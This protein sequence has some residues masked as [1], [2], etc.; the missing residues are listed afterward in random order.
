MNGKVVST[1]HLQIR[2]TVQDYIQAKLEELKQPVNLEKPKG[3]EQLVEA[4]YKALLSK[5][6]RKYSA[7][8]DL[9]KHIM[10]A[11]RINVEKNEPINI[12]FLHG[13]YKLWRLEETPEADWA[14]L[15]SLMYYSNW[16][17]PIC[18]IYEPG[19][20]F[21]FF[22]D[23]LII[24]KLDNIDLADVTAYMDSYQSLI[25]F[26]KQ[27]QPSNLKMTITTVGG[28]F[29]SP[30]A[31]DESV[32]SNLEK[33]TAETPGG[34][35]ELTESQAA[36][37]ELNTKA[38]DEQLK[39]PKWR[40]KVYHL[41]NAYMAT[42]AEPGYHKNRPEKIMAF[43]QPLPS[44]TTISVGS[45]KSSVMKFWVGVG[46]L[47]PKDGSFSQVILSL[48]QLEKADFSYD[49]IRIEGL[50]GKNFNRIRVMK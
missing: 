49:Y 43:T 3:T 48:G 16:V 5:K 44:G 13:A 15:F 4:I 1:S 10:N 35:P 14:E 23:D 42:K 33:L 11:I 25:D 22:V 41:H 32:Q 21:D 6:F 27:Y 38:T 17:K 24:P 47:Q 46:V 31:F 29:E 45:T 18:E 9:Q 8:E 28:Q 12:T 40:E 34:L 36:M 20:W 39:D 2:M 7:N 30:Q 50:N 37:V 19:V 26:L